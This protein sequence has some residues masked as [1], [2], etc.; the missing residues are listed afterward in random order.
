M[1]EYRR[2]KKEEAVELLDFINL[3]FSQNSRPHDFK[4]MFPHM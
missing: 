1:V 2:A 4:K 3:V